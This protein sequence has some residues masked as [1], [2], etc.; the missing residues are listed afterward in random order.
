MV[1]KTESDSSRLDSLKL[2]VSLAVLALGVAGFYLL[3]DAGTLVRVLGVVA[4][5][6]VAAGIFYTSSTGRAAWEFARESR[7]ELRKVVWPTRQET[8]QTTLVVMLVVILVGI[9]LW[10]LDSLLLWVVKALTGQ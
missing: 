8:V 3:S 1:A 6:A 2:A 5:V 9:F 10:L 4:A 7:T